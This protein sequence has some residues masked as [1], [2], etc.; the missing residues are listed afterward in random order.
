MSFKGFLAVTCVVVP[1]LLVQHPQ[2]KTVTVTYDKSV[3]EFWYPSIYSIDGNMKFGTAAIS[4]A[5]EVKDILFDYERRKSYLCGFSRCE[6][7]YNQ[8]RVSWLRQNG[9]VNEARARVSA[10]ENDIKSLSSRLD[11][12]N[13]RRGDLQRHWDA[14]KPPLLACTTSS[15]E[16]AV[17]LSYCAIKYAGP[18]ICRDEVKKILPQDIS[19]RL[20]GD[21]GMEMCQVAI[22]GVLDDEYQIFS[23]FFNK[24]FVNSGETI[25]KELSKL[26]DPTFGEIV[27]WG[28]IAGKVNAC[29]P[30]ARRRCRMVA[31]RWESE[32]ASLK[33]SL[34]KAYSDTTQLRD[35]ILHEK[36]EAELKLYDLNL[37]LKAATEARRAIEV[38]RYKFK[39]RKGACRLI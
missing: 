12:L 32:T 21:I 30:S 34:Q 37:R 4:Y 11:A 20:R 14:I 17:A 6:P 39:C 5:G 18:K 16:N 38:Q 7:L 27:D 23:S 36:K 19:S 24:Y 22:N 29:V 3:V 25:I 31:E 9:L 35:R 26:I 8:L 1:A 15:K 2:V 28:F 33:A 10:Q 13:S